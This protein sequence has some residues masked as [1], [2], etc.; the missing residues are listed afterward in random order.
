MKWKEKKNI[1]QPSVSPQGRNTQWH[2][3]R[4]A[5]NLQKKTQLKSIYECLH[6]PVL[7]NLIFEFYRASLPNFIRDVFSSF[8]MVCFYIPAIRSLSSLS[9]NRS[10]YNF[11]SFVSHQSFCSL[12]STWKGRDSFFFVMF[13]FMDLIGY[14]SC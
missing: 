14:I 9:L 8:F 4:D 10:L 13:S 6:Y 7:S 2:K 12:L 11:P 3:E 5:P 1:F